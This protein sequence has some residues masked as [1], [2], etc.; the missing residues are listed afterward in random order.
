ML[1]AARRLPTLLGRRGAILGGYGTVWLLYGYALLIEPHADRRG[2]ELLLQALPLQAWAALWMAAGLTA[3]VCAWLPQ[4]R[5]MPGFVALM[6]IVLPWMLS[7]LVSWWPLG[8]FSRGWI[9]T[10]IWAALTAP[11]AVVAGW[12]EPPRD[13]KSTAYEHDH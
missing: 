4:G 2:L 12:P 11:V 5:D 7:Y 6:L 1:R 3:M 8:S 9:G 13:R 10:L